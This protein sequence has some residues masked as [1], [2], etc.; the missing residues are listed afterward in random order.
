[1]S[2]TETQWRTARHVVRRAVR[3]SLHCSI[4]SRNPDGSPH[5]TPIG[6]VLLD[7][8]IG[9]AW[10]FDVFNT[11]LAANVDAD[12]RV[13]I[14]AVDS[15]RGLWLRALATGVFA[16]PPGIRLIG[17]V[18]PPRPST[19]AEVARFHRTI[20]PLLHTRGGRTAWG[21]LARVRDIQVDSVDPISIGTMTR[22]E[23][24]RS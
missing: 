1:M 10:Y 18:G 17:A 7:H 9:T 24:S 12:P 22:P 19:P 23:L 20:G 11:R 21:R 16:A 6:S 8:D 13:T 3:S 14:L 4:A 5:V 15:G 2:I